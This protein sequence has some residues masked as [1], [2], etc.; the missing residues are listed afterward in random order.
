MT[1]EFLAFSKY[2]GND[3][4]GFTTIQLPMNL[5]EQEGIPCAKWAKSK[6]LR[7]LVN[8][9][10]NAQRGPKMYRLADYDEPRDYFHH[11]NAVLELFEGAEGL[12]ALYNLITELD[13]NKHRFGWIG[14]YEQFFHAQIVPHLRQAFEAL[15]EKARVAVAETLD[16]F[17][18][19]YAKMVRYECAKK[20]R[21][22]LAACEKPLQECAMEFLLG[23]DD[24]DFV[25]TGMR[26]PA[27]IAEF[28]G[29]T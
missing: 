16:Q 15:D 21:E 11:L 14:D 25:L 13:N 7:V 29:T 9:P 5:L 4:H 10:L 28:T 12:D 23:R 1:A 24:V 6:G 3:Q 26:K 8:R 2:V 18:S 22:E 17:F 27:Y 20:T 19:Q